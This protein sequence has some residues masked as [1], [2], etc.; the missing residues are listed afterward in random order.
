MI[1]HPHLTNIVASRSKEAANKIVNELDRQGIIMDNVEE[2]IGLEK[3][4]CKIIEETI[5][6]SAT[7]SFV[8]TPTIPWIDLSNLKCG[9]G[10]ENDLQN[11]L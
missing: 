4:I 1:P 5:E 7:Y 10:W 6:V 8:P 2:F 3:R 9:D 11:Q